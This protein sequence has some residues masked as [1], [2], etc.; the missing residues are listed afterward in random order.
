MQVRA[1]IVALAIAAVPACGGGAEQARASQAVPTFTRD[2]APILYG[3]CV[4]CH[5]EGQ[6]AVPFALMTYADAATRADRIARMTGSRRMPPWLPDPIEPHFIGER[7]LTDAQIDILRRWAAAGAPEGDPAALPPQPTFAA[8]WQ[9]G[10]PDLVVRPER[11]Y[12]LDPVGHDVFRSVVIRTP[13]TEDRFVRAVEFDPGQAP[14]HHAIIRVDPGD[15]SRRLDGLDG[16]P[17]FEGMP[18]LEV[19]SPEGHFVGW[20]PGR[21]PNVAP[22]GM[23]WRL[24]EG[25]DL[26]VE[27]HMI[28][29]EE[30]VYVRP[31]IAIFFADA[32]PVREPVVFVMGSKALE[33]PPGAADYAVTDTYTL[34]V[35]AELLSLYP[36]AHY[37]GKQMHV[38]VAFPDG[39][40]QTLIHIPQWS[41]KWQQDYRYSEPVALPRGTTIRMRFTYD[42]SP[43][44]ETNPTKPPRLV[45]FGPQSS[46]EMANLLL[47]FATRSPADST[48][49]QRD[50]ER[51]DALANVASSE[52]LVRHFPRDAGHRANL[53]GSYLEVGRLGEAIRELEEA[54]RLDPD[55]LHAQNFLGGA[56]FNAGRFDDAIRHLQRAVTLAPDH[57]PLHYNLGRALGAAGRT[58][59]AKQEFQRALAIDPD[60][61]EAHQG[62]G[63]MLFAEKRMAEALQHLKRAVDLLPAS[64]AAHSDYGGAL[65]QVGRYSEALRSVQ[66]ALEL[67]PTYGPA[68]ENLARL[69]QVV[70]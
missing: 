40:V 6:H 65:A 58:A 45:T 47:Q 22:E 59:D 30:P 24:A 33:I 62:M 34:P 18:G 28:P 13:I 16:Q 35:D 36:H 52:M 21:G 2:V 53:G 3:N 11:A 63:A 55:H 69:Q 38:D 31:E 5:R 32:P 14:V 9:L 26:V 29:G 67:D 23:P 70:R 4:T 37:L 54:V 25:A 57:A 68:R 43:A 7:R 10:E 51:K 27:L 61:A 66:R 48:R 12:R 50:F 44:N 39:S 20:A 60:L 19:K 41:F 49:I 46:D 56:Y 1:A 15:G 64:A 42:N 17:G 8:G